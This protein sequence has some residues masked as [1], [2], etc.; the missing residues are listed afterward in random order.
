[1]VSSERD[2]K[3]KPS[4]STKTSASPPRKADVTRYS[5][6]MGLC[7]TTEWMFQPD[8]E[9]DRVK[10]ALKDWTFPSID[11]WALFPMGRQARAKRARSP[12]SSQTSFRNQLSAGL[13]ALVRNS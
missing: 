9:Q 11:L 3:R 2:R 7:V 8:L 10:Q 13:M 5:P 4:R 1:M 12:A 6:G